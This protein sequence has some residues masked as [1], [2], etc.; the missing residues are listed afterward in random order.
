MSLFLEIV[1][2][3]LLVIGIYILTL[4]VL[5]DTPIYR[6][7]VEISKR[8]G[9]LKFFST[10]FWGLILPSSFIK[11]P[12]TLKVDYDAYGLY[13]IEKACRKAITN[14][15]K[16]NR[17]IYDDTQ[18]KLYDGNSTYVLECNSIGWRY[19][20]M[21]SDADYFLF[22]PYHIRMIMAAAKASKQK[23]DIDKSIFD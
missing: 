17:V 19:N 13:Y 9:F 4:F 16:Y 22:P 10:F 21:R 11:I 1:F 12:Y 3:V 7:S 15:S 6:Y 23:E 8:E 20:N 14:P 2:Y 18:I 5:S